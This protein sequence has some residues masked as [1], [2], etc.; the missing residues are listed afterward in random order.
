MTANESFL[1]DE[2]FYEELSSVPLKQELGS[3]RE[4]NLDLRSWCGTQTGTRWRAMPE[5]F[6]TESARRPE[7]AELL[8]RLPHSLGNELDFLYTFIL[9]AL[10]HIVPNLDTIM[11]SHAY[12][13]WLLYHDLDSGLYREHIVHPVKVAVIARWLLK[14]SGAMRRVKRHLAGKATAPHVKVLLRHLTL[15]EKVLLESPD[16]DKIILAALWLAGLLHDLGYG[17]NFLCNI[18]RR[19]RAAYGFYPG[20]VVGS[21]V[22][23]M[24]PVLIERSLLPRYL[25]DP[26]AWEAFQ[27]SGKLPEPENKSCKESWRLTLYRNLTNNH[28]IA[29]ALNLLCLL[30]ELVEYWPEID[31]RLVLVFELATEAIFLHDLAHEDKFEHF[32]SPRAEYPHSKDKW[33]SKQRPLI[34]FKDSPLAVILILADEIQA[35]GRPRLCYQHGSDP[36]QVTVHFDARRRD[37]DGELLE[38]GLRHGVRFAWEDSQ[39]DGNRTLRLDQAAFGAIERLSHERSRF[40]CAGFIRIGKLS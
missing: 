5:T 8:R 17:H 18:D 40:C 16:G 2:W 38:K 6:W 23:G 26:K 14:K 35:W 3:F 12:S 31:S 20:G 36:D 19:M 15:S 7:L 29:G 32:V 10:R 22:A 34:N 30:Q 28:S 9:E 33:P 27:E 24:N 1:N 11:A 4:P 39:T 13:E 25:L 37:K 21:T